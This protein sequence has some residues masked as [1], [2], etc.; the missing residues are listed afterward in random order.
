MIPLTAFAEPTEAL[1]EIDPVAFGATVVTS[2]NCAC[3]GAVIKARVQVIVPFAPTAGVVQFQPAGAVIDWK[4]SCAGSASV[5]VTFAAE[6][7]PLFAVS[8][9]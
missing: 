6:S 7:G 5:T 2:V 9:V 8:I 4:R 1:F 3:E